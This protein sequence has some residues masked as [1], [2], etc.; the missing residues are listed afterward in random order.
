MLHNPTGACLSAANAYRI[1]Q[2]AE[3]HNFHVVEDDTYSDFHPGTTTRLAALDQLNRVIYIGSF[4]KTL[5][6]DLRVGYMTARPDIFAS[7]VDIKVLTCLTTPAT[8]EELIYRLLTEGHYRKLIERLRDR[9]GE[10]TARALRMVER[11]GLQPF[12][13]SQGGVFI[14]ARIPGMEDAVDLATRAAKENIIL[15]PGSLFRPQGQASPWLR[16]NV[17]YANDVRLERFLGEALGKVVRK[18]IVNHHPPTTPHSLRNYRLSLITRPF[19]DCTG[20]ALFW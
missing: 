12:I 20:R 2:C 3:R 17:V 16:L 13:P 7:L 9:L 6:G 15:A 18:R 14:W 19:C 10:A 1:L 11:V 4:S 5:S 8:A